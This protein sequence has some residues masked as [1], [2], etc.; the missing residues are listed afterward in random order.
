[1]QSFSVLMSVYRN[2]KPTDFRIAVESVSVKQTVRPDEVLI[3]VDGPV[4]DVLH[5]MIEDLASE[6]GYIRILWQAENKG[7]GVALSIGIENA[8]NEIIA[9]MDSDDIADPYRFEKQLSAF[10][11]DPELSII[12]SNITEF[13][14]IPSN[15]V[16]K[17]EVPTTNEKICRYMRTR[18]GFNHVTVMYKRSEVLK[19][20]NYQD[21]Y[22]NE[23]YF[24]WIRMM[25][26]G[27]KFANLEEN[28]VNV[29]VGRD[30]YARRGSLKYF[31]SEEGI[32][33][34]MYKNHIIGLLQYCFNVLVRFIV[35]V[36]M[37]NW[38]RGWVFQ[39]FARK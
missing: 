8:T 1:M 16:G 14:N 26:A 33:R 21:W 37:P 15:I 22:C 30:M 10:E 12:G 35:Q 34:F 7:L 25:I 6:I 5:K 19:A 36:C 13:V 2:D 23:D 38:L 24:L 29:R 18:C 9:R 20:G 17:R 4:P 39:E 31:K 3:I 11:E 32:Q 28:L 27:C